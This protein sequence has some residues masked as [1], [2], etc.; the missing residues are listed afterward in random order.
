METEEEKR[1]RFYEE[2]QR[3]NTKICDNK[4][5]IEC[6]DPPEVLVQEPCDKQPEEEIPEPLMVQPPE[7]PPDAC[8]VKGPGL[9]I[10]AERCVRDKYDL[11]DLK[12]PKNQCNCTLYEKCP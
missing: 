4:V 1:Q 9:A 11:C 6:Q 3:K 12:I 5:P 8:R 10:A 7:F 2:V